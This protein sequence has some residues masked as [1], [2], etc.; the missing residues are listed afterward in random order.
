MAIVRAIS[1]FPV[2]ARYLR[3]TTDTTSTTTSG[4]GRLLRPPAADDNAPVTTF[5]ATCDGVIDG[6]AQCGSMSARDT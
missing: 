1:T 6:P 4:R 3:A 2:V 5:P